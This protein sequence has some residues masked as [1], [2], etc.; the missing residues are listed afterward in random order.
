MRRFHAL[1]YFLSRADGPSARNFDGVSVGRGCIG[2]REVLDDATEG[3]D[4]PA[5]FMKISI[6]SNAH[7]ARKD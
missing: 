1:S 3:F 5:S 7:G 4:F 2:K 6:L